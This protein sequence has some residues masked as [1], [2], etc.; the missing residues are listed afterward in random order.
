ME[1]VGYGISF[2]EIKRCLCGRLLMG[3]DII[4]FDI[5]LNG[6]LRVA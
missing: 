1:I 2:I 6:C 5:V 3:S 4:I